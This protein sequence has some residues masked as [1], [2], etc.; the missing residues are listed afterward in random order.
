MDTSNVGNLDLNTVMSV[1]EQLR[2]EFIS[3]SQLEQYQNSEDINVSL[4]NFL[5]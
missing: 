2:N 3:I 1:E 5:S 4:L